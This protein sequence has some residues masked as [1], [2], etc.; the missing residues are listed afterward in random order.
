M[1]KN[2]LHRIKAIGT[3]NGAVKSLIT[4]VLMFVLPAF[5]DLPIG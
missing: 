2:L 4:L 5:S 1:G 3:V